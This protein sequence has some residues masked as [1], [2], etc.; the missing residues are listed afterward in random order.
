VDGKRGGGSATTTTSG[1]GSASGMARAR[2]QRVKRAGVVEDWGTDMWA[3]YTVS[4]G[5]EFD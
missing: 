5:G 4:G 1:G 3:P 2:W